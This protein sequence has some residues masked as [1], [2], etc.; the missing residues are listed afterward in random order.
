M[1]ILVH[2]RGAVGKTM[3]SS[4]VR[5]YH[6]ARVLAEQLPDARVTLSVPHKAEIPS[7]HPRLTIVRQRGQWSDLLQMLRHDIIVSRNFPPHAILLLFHKLWAL[8][9]YSTFFIE[10]LELTRR[11]PHAGRRRIW[12]D[13]N[14]HY[15][16][17]QLAMADYI[18]CANERQRDVLVGALAATGLLTSNV[19][20]RD[21]TLRKLVDVVPYG[22]QP[23]CPQPGRKVLKGVIPGIHEADTVLIW[24]GSIMEWFDAKTVIRAMAEIARV[25]DDVKL[26]FLGTEH[27]DFV[28]G[29]LETPP[30]EAV[31][32]SKE[33]GLY[34]RSVF[35]NVGWVP[36]EELGAY[37]A[38]ADIGVCAGFD[39]TE[40]RYAFRTRFV[41]LFWAELPTVCTE[42]DVLAER[43]AQ[44][45]LGLAV[46]PSDPSAFAQAVLRLV[47]DKAFY[48][49]CKGNMAAVREE[50]GWD[51]TLMPLVEFCRRGKSIAAPKRQ[52]LMPLLRHAIGYLQTHVRQNRIKTSE[53]G[54][55]VALNA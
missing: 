40:A 21:R 33:L 18:V 30:R 20:E 15:I 54:Q 41:D 36:Y 45:P 11:I 2:S 53:P 27:P 4:G 51:R 49:Q 22:V 17:F 7:P 37:L 9:F 29:V 39:S 48:E 42:G 35:F 46:S 55:D 52:R 50:L 6:T 47:D 1:K 43:V 24:N 28:T 5:A 34:E 31:E 3:A 12:T 19:Y 13:S 26:F 38:E 16:N 44:G 25:R 10:W 32:L 23:G 8:D 14:R